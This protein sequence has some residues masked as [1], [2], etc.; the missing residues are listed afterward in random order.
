[1][2]GDGNNFVRT[3]QRLAADGVNP[4]VVNDQH[5]RLTFT[6]EIARAIA[7]LLK[8]GSPFGTYNVTNSGDVVTWFDIAREVFALNGH[9][10]DRVS[11]ITAAEFAD[12]NS[13]D[14]RP[15]AP[16]PRNSALNLGKLRAT[17]FEPEDWRT[18]LTNN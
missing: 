12:R 8:Q 3:M 2:I 1:V 6:S 5:G 10:P 18:A 17:E 4:D 15:I 14:K 7:H 9:E 11:P 16:R 13:S